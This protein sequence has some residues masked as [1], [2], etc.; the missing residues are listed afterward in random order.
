M[1][2]LLADARGAVR[3]DRLERSARVLTKDEPFRS[4]KTAQR[5]QIIHEQS[6]IVEYAG[7]TAIE[8]LPDLLR[9]P[10]E[11]R[12]AAEVVQ[13]VPGALSDM[14][15]RTLAMLQR[16]RECSACRPRRPM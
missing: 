6:L 14:E 11:R 5:A 7:A 16:F 8:T 12:R 2:I 9:T 15:P 13:F 1:L 10:E 3:R 4:L